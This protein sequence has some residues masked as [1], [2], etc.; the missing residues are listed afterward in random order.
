MQGVGAIFEAYRDQRITRDDAVMVCHAPAELNYQPLTIALVDMEA[1]L[2]AADLDPQERRQLQRIARRLDF[3]ER[4]WPRCLELYRQRTGKT[5]SLDALQL[6][7]IGSVKQRDAQRL[8]QALRATPPSFIERPRPPLTSFYMA[9]LEKR[10][11]SPLS[12]PLRAPSHALLAGKA[13]CN[14]SKRL[15]RLSSARAPAATPPEIAI[16]TDPSAWREFLP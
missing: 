9:M 7:A 12:A 3:R 16:G 15:C 8:V 5:A 4:S 2:L 11:R 10:A 6:E 13:G 1:A 14:A